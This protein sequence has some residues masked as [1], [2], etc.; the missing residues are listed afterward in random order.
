MRRAAK[1]TE[2]EPVEIPPELPDTRTLEVDGVCV[3]EYI[4]TK[5]TRPAGDQ[6]PTI[7]LLHG[8]PGTVRDF[9]YLIPLLQDRARIVAINLPGFGESRALQK[10]DR[11]TVVHAA[12]SGEITY[13]AIC[14]ICRG[15]P[16]VFVIGHSFGGHFAINVVAAADKDKGKAG[17]NVKGMALVA[18]AGHRPHHTLAP[19]SFK[20][21]SW[22]IESNSTF[23]S[24]ATMSLTGWLYVNIVGFP[25]SQPASYYVSAML[26]KNS[27]N[28]DAVMQQLREINHVPTLVA[29][30]KTDRHIE[31]ELSLNISHLSGVG[32]RIAFVGGGHN[33]QK[34]RASALASEL[35]SWMDD[36]LMQRKRDYS[37]DAVIILK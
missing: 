25:R 5:P 10:K 22:L 28:Y 29:W 20:V 3:I 32:P 37:K 19:R 7:V 27:T 35:L 23:I 9:R 17:L 15:D 4:D 1:H 18:S 21:L 13:R 14:E 16:N 11:F 33:I 2:N 31:E 34:T 30:R 26:R 36:V 24:K 6:T 12:E 8:A